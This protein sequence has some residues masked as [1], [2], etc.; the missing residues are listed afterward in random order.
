[1]Y[2]LLAYFS[3]RYSINDVGSG[4]ACSCY[5]RLII[6]HLFLFEFLHVGRGLFCLLLK[7]PLYRAH[8]VI[9]L[10]KDKNWFN[11]FIY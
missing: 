5:D 2:A 9:G 4:F 6:H 10:T 7:T 1:M 3:R 11:G 8:H